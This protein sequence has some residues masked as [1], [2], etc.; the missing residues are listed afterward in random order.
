VVPSTRRL[1]VDPRAL[2]LGEF[3]LAK[4]TP[5]LPELVAK[6]FMMGIEALFAARTNDPE[7]ACQD[8]LL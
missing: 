8:C 7:D 2:L 4:W 6:V 3:Q 1:L 5:E